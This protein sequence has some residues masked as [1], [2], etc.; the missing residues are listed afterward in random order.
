MKVIKFIFGDEW[1][2][3]LLGYGVGAL[4]YA[5]G[6]GWKSAGIAT[7]IALL[8]RLTNELQGKFPTR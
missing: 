2:S 5:S 1:K 3:T 8:G 7:G 6:H 4:Q